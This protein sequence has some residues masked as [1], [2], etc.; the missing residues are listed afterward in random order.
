VSSCDKSSGEATKVKY[1][2]YSTLPVSNDVLVREKL[3]G[4]YCTVYAAL[5][6]SV[7]VWQYRV[8][9]AEP[10]SQKVLSGRCGT[11]YIDAALPPAPELSIVFFVYFPPL[12]KEVQAH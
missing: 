1:E 11:F 8:F 6:T 2:A 4:C 3:Y 9:Y 7:P 10:H 5:S 12:A